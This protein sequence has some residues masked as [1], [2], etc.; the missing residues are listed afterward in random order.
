MDELTGSGGVSEQ[1][2]FEPVLKTDLIES[3]LDQ[4]RSKIENNFAS[5]NFDQFG[6]ISNKLR[7]FGTSIQNMGDDLLRSSQSVI[8]SFMT[9]PETISREFNNV[10]T[11]IP[12]GLDFFASTGAGYNYASPYYRSQYVAEGNKE[13]GDKVGDFAADNAGTGF[14]LAVGSMVGNP[15][16]GLAAGF[17]FDYTVGAGIEK[18]RAMERLSDNIFNISKYQSGT[19]ISK[20]MASEITDDI[21]GRTE[22]FDGLA[23]DLSIEEMTSNISTFSQAGGFK[24]VR[25]TDEF[26]TT[27]NSII[28]DTRDIS[29]TLGMFQ[30]EVVTLMAELKNKGI[31]NVSSA[32]DFLLDLKGRADSVGANTNDLINQGMQAAQ[33][34]QGN[35][36]GAINAFN[37]GVDAFVE[38]QRLYGSN[39]DL[40]GSSIFNQ[41]G[42]GQATQNLMSNLMS[43]NSQTAMSQYYNMMMGNSPTGS[44]M[45]LMNSGVDFFNQY[46]TQGLLAA[47]GRESEMLGKMDVTTQAQI[48]TQRAI[49]MA[50]LYRQTGPDGKVNVDVAAAFLMQSTPGLTRDA[51][52]TMIGVGTQGGQVE[53]L[54][55]GQASQLVNSMQSDDPS[56]WGK[57]SAGAEYVWEGIKSPFIQTGMTVDAAGNAIGDVVTDITDYISGVGRV[58]NKN[59]TNNDIDNVTSGV[60]RDI[61]ERIYSNKVVKSDLKSI[62]N[63]ANELG[64]LDLNVLYRGGIGPGERLKA[65][66]S[67]LIALGNGFNFKDS[68]IKDILNYSVDGQNSV[69]NIMSG[70]RKFA[71]SNGIDN[72]SDSLITL[73]IGQDTRLNRA[74]QQ[75]DELKKYNSLQEDLDN[76][77][78][79]AYNEIKAN[80]LKNL[81][82]SISIFGDGFST[83]KESLKEAGIDVN[84]SGAKEV[85]K[86]IYNYL[87]K[88]D[89]IFTNKTF[90]EIVRNTL[91][92]SGNK[93]TPEDI[94]S[95]NKTFNK[96]TG[97]SFSRVTTAG[98]RD[99][100]T[101]QLVEEAGLDPN[102]IDSFRTILAGDAVFNKISKG[103][104]FTFDKE[105]AIR[106]INSIHKNP[107]G[108]AEGIAGDE[109]SERM[110][111]NINLTSLFK[112]AGLTSDD[113]K[114][115][116]N[117]DVLQ[118]EVLA[119]QADSFVK[120]SDGK[121]SILTTQTKP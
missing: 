39:N 34:S 75:T 44:G 113:L 57:M 115:V 114:T 71:K 87:N 26:R 2:E 105:S 13:F 80:D 116:S 120:G 112:S 60:R 107:N 52:N 100:I 59:V 76:S 111:R 30:D 28:E 70:V 6:G 79:D 121:W 25:S 5:T 74:I 81:R 68:D 103:G 73:A 98:M 82:D 65:T 54:M 8:N 47:A 85:Y 31:T 83:I 16:I 62:Q 41:G 95:F 9:A 22:S 7:D 117:V 64:G 118:M 19:N 97:N 4:I 93:A 58:R 46:G 35:S 27:I 36:F 56:I 50:N 12:T 49:E 43:A 14:G 48:A 102:D 20:D 91:L 32:K 94:D 29:K 3:Q 92:I 66:D 55:S 33:M 86:N 69:Q 101:E 108:I 77:L 78:G 10:Q 37:F 40:Y 45:D 84:E 110:A 17:A 38:T 11:N 1:I 24:N 106:A 109:R 53:Q 90:N 63:A 18:N 21:Y 61:D 51:A 96:N 99:S 104:D 72:P 119:K 67:E 42:V 88:K 89:T 23:R 15:L